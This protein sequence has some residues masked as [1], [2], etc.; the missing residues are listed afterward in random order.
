[1]SRV[2]RKRNPRRQ[3][4]WTLCCC[5]LRAAGK[6]GLLHACIRS[7][8][9]S[10]AAIGARLQPSFLQFSLDCVKAGVF[11]IDISTGEFLDQ[12]SA[13]GTIREVWLSRCPSLPR[14]SKTRSVG[15]GL[16]HN[17]SWPTGVCCH[18][19]VEAQSFLR[20]NQLSP[21]VKLGWT[22]R[23]LALAECGQRLGR[24]FPLWFLSFGGEKLILQDIS[25]QLYR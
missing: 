4:L 9:L 10:L 21:G 3:D 16:S 2:K 18:P 22:A 24:M 8:T 20:G 1:M 25:P 14:A 23:R 11:A 13:S 7:N 12:L 17:L 15:P 19:L 6:D 5:I